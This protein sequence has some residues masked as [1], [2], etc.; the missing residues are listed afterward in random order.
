[1]SKPIIFMTGA[2]G[3]IGGSILHLML[4]RGYLQQYDIRVLVR[5][6]AD[7]ARLAELGIHLVL[8]T[9]EDLDLIQAQSAESDIVF[10][11]ASCDHETS[12]IAIIDGL[13]L[14]AN[15]QTLRPILI[16]TS[17]A[18]VLT[19]KSKGIGCSPAA[20]REAKVWDDADAQAH[21]AIPDRAP[22]RHVD[23]HI[24]NAAD[25][26]LIK[27]YLMVPPTVFGVG[28][29]QFAA[30]R[31]SIQIPRLV[32]PSLMWRKSMY[33]GAGENGWPN[34][35]VADLAELYLLL[36]NAALEDRA[37][38]GRAGLYYPVSEHYQWRDVAK[39]VGEVMHARGLI[40]DAEPVSG[41]HEGWFWG[42]NLQVETTNSKALGWSPR[43]GG[44]SEMLSL[45]EHDVELVLTAI[46]KTKR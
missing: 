4:Q 22:H 10:N 7:A 21:A 14:R 29:G 12:A 3:Y 35:H 44:T 32:Y 11:T 15:A 2:T 33:V 9:L 31:M 25:S 36:M 34:V 38:V 13:T 24:F 39:K 19:D 46:T 5:R 37:P 27:T 28:L 6:S 41:L 18:G 42:S 20:D 17:G 30:S 45:V 40:D 8:G 23:L 43:H 1:M 26:G 16:H